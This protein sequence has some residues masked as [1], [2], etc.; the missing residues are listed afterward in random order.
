M[1]DIIIQIIYDKIKDI[2]FYNYDN[3]KEL[4]NV[5]VKLYTNILN[6]LVIDVILEHKTYTITC[7]QSYA[8]K[9]LEND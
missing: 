3:E 6:E 9:E 8:D 7:F 2:N 5:D 1:E 4:K